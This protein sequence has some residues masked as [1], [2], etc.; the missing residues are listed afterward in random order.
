[1]SDNFLLDLRKIK[2]ISDHQFGIDITDVLFDDMDKIRIE[3]SK[4]TNKIRYLYYQ[5]DLMLNLR[6]E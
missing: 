6:N 1:M 5:N 2:A 3:K 4:N